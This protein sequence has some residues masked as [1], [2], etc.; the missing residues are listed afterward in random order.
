MWSDVICS[1]AV[2][3][4]SVR[5]IRGGYRGAAPRAAGTDSVKY[6][7]LSRS[8]SL[9]LQEQVLSNAHINRKRYGVF[10]VSPTIEIKDIL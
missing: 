9:A 1:P 6:I 10:P 8:R 7:L 2:F 3:Q 4:T 5:L